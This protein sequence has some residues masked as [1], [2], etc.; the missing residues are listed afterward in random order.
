VEFHHQKAHLGGMIH[1]RKIR[2][3]ANK[4][5]RH[6]RK[7]AARR[8]RGKKHHGIS[9]ASCNNVVGSQLGEIVGRYH[10][11]CFHAVGLFGMRGGKSSMDLVAASCWRPTKRSGKRSSRVCFVAELICQFHADPSKQYEYSYTSAF[12]RPTAPSFKPKLTM[13]KRR[14]KMHKAYRQLSCHGRREPG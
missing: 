12:G 13:V 7:G 11:S 14:T 3:H 5:S 2:Q 6:I 4:P 9:S 8:L 10:H 1:L